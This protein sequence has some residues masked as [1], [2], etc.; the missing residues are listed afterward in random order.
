MAYDLTQQPWI[1]VRYVVGEEGPSA[2][3]LREALAEA[4][5][6][7]EIE[8]P[9][10]QTAALYRLLQAL[11]VR[12]YV[13]PEDAPDDADW[14]QEAWYDLWE[15]GRF[16]SG[17][18]ARYFDRWQDERER[19]DL[20]HPDRPF[21]GHPEPTTP[22]DGAANWLVPVW[23]KGNNETLFDH[24]TDAM[25]AAMPLDEAARALVATQAWALGG[26][27]GPGRLRFEDAPLSRG[28]VFWLRGDSLFEALLLNTPPDTITRMRS[29]KRDA[30]SWERDTPS[31]RKPGAEV[32]YL[33]FLTWP[34]R[35]VRLDVDETGDEPVVCGVQIAQGKKWVSEA[36]DPLNAL[37]TKKDGGRYPLKLRPEQSLWRAAP[38]YLGLRLDGQREAPPRPF[39]WLVNSPRL[40]RSRAGGW[41][42]EV[43]GLANDKAKMEMI[44]ADRLT[45]YPTILGSK[46]A[47]RYVVEAVKRASMQ[48]QTLRY[49]LRDCA[50]R[51]A[52][53]TDAADVADGL[54]GERRFWALLETGFVQGR[55]RE[56]AFDDWLGALADL[57]AAHDGDAFADRADRHLARWTRTLHRAAQR[58]Y[59]AATDGLIGT[60]R[61][62]EAV[63]VGRDRLRPAAAYADA[64]SAPAPTS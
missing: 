36:T 57:T 45:V 5:R 13:H 50:A 7:R 28:A 51:L 63:A 9:P 3:G 26:L 27:A 31:D 35:H 53:R 4:H 60:P 61:R 52:T 43:F 25:C 29:G 41:D 2:V 54:Q 33:D 49:A 8:A 12:L 47:Q 17:R 22:S 6:I 62:M 11:F 58:A 59:D 64:L 39:D 38:A 10:L 1:P 48:A 16:D 46:S 24:T 44:R 37:R 21:Y 55:D 23:A 56:R 32:G 18:V 19:F 20:L 14:T 15:A 34:S 40:R 30:P 42:V